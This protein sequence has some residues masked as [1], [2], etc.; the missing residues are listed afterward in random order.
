MIRLAVVAFAACGGAIV[1]IVHG[2]TEYDCGGVWCVCLKGA[3]QQGCKTKCT[4]CRQDTRQM[5][6]MMT[7][8]LEGPTDCTTDCTTDCNCTPHPFPSLPRAF[9]P[10]CRCRSRNKLQARRFRIP[11]ALVP[12]GTRHPPFLGWRKVL[13]TPRCARIHG[14]QQQQQHLLTT[15]QIS[16]YQSPVPV[17]R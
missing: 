8:G 13:D 6:R 4:A 12:I 9:P 5:H 17:R 14:Q 10:C 2:R 3:M 11:S 16:L 7:L 15:P 1:R